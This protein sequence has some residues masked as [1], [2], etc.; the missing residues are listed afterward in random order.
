MTSATNNE[1]LTNGDWNRPI[2]GGKDLILR[3]KSALEHL[4]LFVGYMN[5]K[6]IEVYARQLGAV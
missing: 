2:V 3:C 6:M 4:E 1:F 5:E